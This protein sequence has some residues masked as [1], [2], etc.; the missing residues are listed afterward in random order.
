M[1]LL[2][3]SL[4]HAPHVPTCLPLCSLHLNSHPYLSVSLKNQF[5]RKNCPGDSSPDVLP[6]SPTL[7]AL[8]LALAVPLGQ[9]SLVYSFVITKELDQLLGALG[10]FKFYPTLELDPQE[11]GQGSLRNG[12]TLS[13]I[14]LSPNLNI[15]PMRTGTYLWLVHLEIVRCKHRTWHVVSDQ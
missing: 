6:S 11:A 12:L 14:S 15:S 2:S 4:V 9:R 3:H 7:R 5:F 8:V 13:Y 10:L 1:V